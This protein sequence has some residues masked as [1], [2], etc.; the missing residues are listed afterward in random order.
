MKPISKIVIALLLVFNGTSCDESDT[1]ALDS[2]NPI[3]GTWKMVEAS[4]SI[5]GPQ[6]IQQIED[7]EE[8]IFKA[9]GTFS[10]TRWQE[11]T[12][13]N[14]LITEDLLTLNYGCEGFKTGAENDRG[15]LTYLIRFGSD[16]FIL[17]PT[18][19]ICTDGCSYTY[20]KIVR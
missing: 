19:V 18:S 15:A 11:C 5:G 4:S 6:I 20:K 9:D 3:L 2:E 8:F 14:F 17:V 16:S 10:T 12:T 1:I 13:G 7:G